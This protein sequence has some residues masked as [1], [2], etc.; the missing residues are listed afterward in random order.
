MNT[1]KV[2][3]GKP[4][5]KKSSWRDVLPIHPAAE[6][7]PQMSPADLEA[8]SRDI[9]LNGLRHRIVLWAEDPNSKKFLLDGRNRCDAMEMVGIDPLK[10]S[11][12]TLYGSDGVDPWAYVRSANIHRLHQTAEQKREAIAKLLKAAPEKSDRQIAEAVKASPSTVGAVRKSTVQVGQLTEKR[13]G[14]DGKPRKQPAKKRRPRTADDAY[15]AA[16]AKTRT[17]ATS[18]SKIGGP[19]YATVEEAVAA[20]KELRRVVPEKP[21][22]EPADPATPPESLPATDPAKII[23]QCIGAMVGAIEIAFVQLK[24]D[25]GAKATLLERLRS[26]L[27]RLAQKHNCAAQPDSP[28]NS[29]RPEPQDDPGPLPASLDRSTKH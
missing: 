28:G 27:D 17:D 8:L 2:P 4:P 16:Q 23:E 5:S 26:E 18:I 3:E 12:I 11:Q 19:R 13:I 6:T 1:P 24:E 29:E 10:A 14:K 20:V 22:T 15:D 21:T 25:Q 7:S 9:N